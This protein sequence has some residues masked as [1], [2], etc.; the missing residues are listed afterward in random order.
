MRDQRSGMPSAGRRSEDVQVLVLSLLLDS[1]RLAPWPVEELARVVGCERAATGAV[2][3]LDAAG[4]VCRR[5]ALVL[6]T[7]ATRAAS[8]FLQLL[9]E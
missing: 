3:T 5:G 4:L 7:P 9:R 1:E 8:R 6:A 2:V